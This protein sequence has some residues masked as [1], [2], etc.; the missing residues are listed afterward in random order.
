MRTKML[1]CA[2]SET[3]I[4]PTKPIASTKLWSTTSQANTAFDLENGSED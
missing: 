3:S 2:E 1:C 4:E